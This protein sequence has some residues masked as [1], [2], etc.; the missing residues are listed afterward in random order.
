MEDTGP[1][2]ATEGEEHSVYKESNQSKFFSKLSPLV[3]RFK[4]IIVI[5]G[6][7]IAFINIRSMTLIH[8]ESENALVLKESSP[9]EMALQ[10]R[11]KDLWNPEG[12]SIF[13]MYGIKPYI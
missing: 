8:P 13:L 9:L 12:I 6:L 2:E 11:D 4:V 5:I 1:P 10:W 3:H 7:V